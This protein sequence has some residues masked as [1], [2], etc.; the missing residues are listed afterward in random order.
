MQHQLSSMPI[1]TKSFVTVTLSIKAIQI[2]LELPK[3]LNSI[4]S[5]LLLNQILIK[6]LSILTIKQ[7]KYQ[8][9]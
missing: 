3:S 4:T 8:N 7:P 6:E 2:S 5:K 9:L 1:S